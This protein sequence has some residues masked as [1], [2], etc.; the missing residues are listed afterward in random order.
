M[1]E[2]SVADVLEWEALPEET[3]ERF[4]AVIREEIE[5]E[6]HSDLQDERDELQEEG[7]DKARGDLREMLAELKDV[8]GK[9][10]NAAEEATDTIDRLE[11]ELG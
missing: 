4:K 10:A 8:I 2:P 1:T 7:A 6:L 5:Q 9:L 11:D 3:R